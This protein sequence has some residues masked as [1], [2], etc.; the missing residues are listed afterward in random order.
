VGA[1]NWTS[2]SGNTTVGLG[3]TA[4]NELVGRESTRTLMSLVVQ[5]KLGERWKYVFQFDDAYESDSVPGQQG[6]FEGA[7][8]Y[9]LV[10]YL[11]C[12]INP[13]WTAGL[14][15]EWFSDDDGVRVQGLGYPK[16]IPLFPVPSHWHEF[17]V[18]VNYKPNANVTVRS[19]LRW[20]WVDPLVAVPDGPF[21]DFDSRKQLLWSADLIVK[22]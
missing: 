2:A 14:R 6:R 4:S 3:V 16:G 12:E 9:G 5:Q 11:Y 1:V 8:W 13:C 18:G 19:E 10:N 21:D 22:F 20:D 17:A 15:Y 7:E